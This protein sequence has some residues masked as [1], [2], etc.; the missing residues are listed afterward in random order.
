M[1]KPAI[2]KVALGFKIGLLVILLVAGVLL[3]C[4]GYRT[5]LHYQDVKDNAVE[6]T[7]T[8]TR[9]DEWEDSE[10]STYYDVYVKYSYKEEVYSQE[11]DGHRNA[12]V[13]D[14]FAIS[15]NS[16]DP[17][18]IMQ[19][20]RSSYKVTIVFGALCLGL[21]FGTSRMDTRVGWCETFGI[22]RE[23]IHADLLRKVKT[24]NTGIGCLIVAVATAAG[25]CIT[26]K[27]V[28]LLGCGVLSAILGIRKLNTFLKESR[29]IK[30]QEYTVQTDRLVSKRVEEDSEGDSYYVTYRT[31]EGTSYELNVSMKVYNKA[32]EGDQIL[33]VFLP[34]QKKPYMTV[35][36]HSKQIT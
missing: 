17:M 18:E 22:N 19:E 12:D 30:T 14:Q 10:G 2:K 26:R 25:W 15:I 23:M 4:S 11:I 31:S 32:V 21:A 34:Q 28:L 36:L 13:G 9:V 1:E 16:D 27:D 29:L 6:V 7:A 35:D 24:G 3:L 33:S 5:A 8:V 20:T